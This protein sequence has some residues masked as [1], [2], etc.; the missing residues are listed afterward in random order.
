MD[1]IAR[2][3]ARISHASGNRQVHRRELPG[4]AVG[5]SG[6]FGSCP[7]GAGRQVS[8]ARTWSRRPAPQTFETKGDAEGWLGRRRPT[9]WRG[10]GSRPVKVQGG[11]A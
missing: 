11:A 6:T 4:Q 10:S 3:V 9:W 5:A 8:S 1:G 7:R 2:D